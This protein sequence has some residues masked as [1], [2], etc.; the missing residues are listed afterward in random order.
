MHYISIYVSKACD[1]LQNDTEGPQINAVPKLSSMTHIFHVQ[2]HQKS[3]ILY[4]HNDERWAKIIH[5]ARLN[6][7]N[8]ITFIRYIKVFFWIHVAFR[9]VNGCYSL[10]QHNY[11]KYKII[12]QNITTN[13]NEV[14]Y[15][16]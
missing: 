6:T 14:K 11:C 10:I 8:R 4:F 3:K 12:T 5:A 2:A 15:K 16:K 13:N 1:C 9:N 7:T